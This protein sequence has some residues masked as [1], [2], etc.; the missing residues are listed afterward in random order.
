MRYVKGSL[1]YAH[2]RSDDDL[3]KIALDIAS[4]GTFARAGLQQL[5]SAGGLSAWAQGLDVVA[6]AIRHAGNKI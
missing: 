3:L 2:K 6:A 4:E 5:T 1:D